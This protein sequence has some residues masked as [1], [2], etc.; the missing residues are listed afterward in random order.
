[1]RLGDEVIAMP[2]PLSSPLEPVD[3]SWGP[4]GRA[5]DERA[6]F[7]AKRIAN[8][9]IDHVALTAGWPNITNGRASYHY[10]S[11]PCVASLGQLSRLFVIILE[12]ES[13]NA[14]LP[15]WVI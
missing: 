15:L 7:F 14:I 2:G 12:N 10:K 8:T 11:R 9:Y 3:F 5:V 4:L 6:E 1:M 13:G